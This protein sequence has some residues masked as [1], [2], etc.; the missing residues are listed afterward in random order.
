[1]NSRLNKRITARIQ[2]VNGERLLDI[3]EEFEFDADE[4]TLEYDGKRMVMTPR[5][6]EARGSKG[7]ANV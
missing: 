2:R 4:V 3:P 7:R 6:P 1:M 5:E